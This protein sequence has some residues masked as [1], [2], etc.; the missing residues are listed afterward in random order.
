MILLAYA[1]SP[2]DAAT[3]LPGIIMARKYKVFKK[4]GSSSPKEYLLLLED[5]IIFAG[6][7]EYIL[8]QITKL[9]EDDE[10]GTYEAEALLNSV[11]GS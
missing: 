2:I 9:Y 11:R 5:E 3:F 10:I 6:G 8:N 1:G 7:R 4:L